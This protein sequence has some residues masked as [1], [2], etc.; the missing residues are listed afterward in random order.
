[1][2]RGGAGL[3]LAGD[4]RPGGARRVA[5]LPGLDWRG[6]CGLAR[7]GYGWP[8]EFWRGLARLTT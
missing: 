5:D 3:G 1:M 7:S 2:G 6:G 4:V 8:G